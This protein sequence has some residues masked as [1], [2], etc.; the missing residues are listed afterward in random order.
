MNKVSLLKKRAQE[1]K[2]LLTEAERTD[3]WVG[4]VLDELEPLF[5]GIE[6]GSIQPPI[7]FGTYRRKFRS[8]DPKYGMHTAICSAESEF[9]SALEDWPSKSWY[10]PT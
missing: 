6:N 5:N 4:R 1:F 8:D 7:P 3:P 9:N 10:G 2:L